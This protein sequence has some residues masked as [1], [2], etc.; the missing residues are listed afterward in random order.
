M[1]IFLRTAGIGMKRRMAIHPMTQ[2]AGK[3]RLPESLDMKKDMK[4]NL[5]IAGKSYIPGNLDTGRSRSMTRRQAMTR[6]PYM[7]GKTVMAQ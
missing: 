1:T 6:K 2:A 5:P 4:R 7:P 3:P